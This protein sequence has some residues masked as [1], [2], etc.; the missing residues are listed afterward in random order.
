MIPPPGYVTIPLGIWTHIIFESS[1]Q[2]ALDVLQR[3]D[4]V[5]KLC[6]LYKYNVRSPPNAHTH[7]LC[8][9]PHIEGLVCEFIGSVHWFKDPSVERWS[10][11]AREGSGE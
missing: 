3:T 5:I 11:Q 8:T 4:S 2:Q 1:V 6:S 7:T 9:H 10:K